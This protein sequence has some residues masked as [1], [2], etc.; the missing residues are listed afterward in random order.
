MLRFL[1]TY[2]DPHVRCRQYCRRH[3][4]AAAV[5]AITKKYLQRAIHQ[6]ETHN[7]EESN[8]KKRRKNTTSTTTQQYNTE[9]QRQWNVVQCGRSGLT[10]KPINSVALRFF[11]RL[12][13]IYLLKSHFTFR[14]WHQ[15]IC[16]QSGAILKGKIRS[17][18]FSIH[19]NNIH[20]F[21]YINQVF[22]VEEKLF[23]FYDFLQHFQSI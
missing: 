22:L 20:N 13:Y 7:C 21:S 1:C 17:N 12:R 10:Q 5:A 4:V 9:S 2:Y 3:I 14:M 11:L 15:R 8:L 18:H 16:A 19:C 23:C 6:Q